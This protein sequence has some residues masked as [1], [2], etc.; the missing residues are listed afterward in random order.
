M[1]RNAWQ[2][3]GRQNNGFRDNWSFQERVLS[4]NGGA[5]CGVRGSSGPVRDCIVPDA[6]CQVSHGSVDTMGVVNQRVRSSVFTHTHC[7]SHS[8]KK[9]KSAKLARVKE[10]R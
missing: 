3:G 10:K 1:R 6:L 4:G 9:I 5:G 2:E 7:C 8:A